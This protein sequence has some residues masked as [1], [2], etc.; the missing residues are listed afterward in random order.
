MT[1]GA[2]AADLPVRKSPP[3]GLQVVAP[4]FTWTG[5]YA[6]VHAGWGIAAPKENAADA[7]VL[8]TAGYSKSV[9]APN[10]FLAGPYIGANYQFSNNVVIG[11]EA[12]YSFSAVK[13]KAHGLGD[14][15]FGPMAY[16]VNAR[17]QN[18]G[19]VLGR[20]G[21][22]F[23]RWRPYVTAGFAWGRAKSTVQ[24]PGFASANANDH[25]GWVAGA[26][27][28]YAATNNVILRAEAMY[29]DL[30][31]KRYGQLVPVRVHARGGLARVG[32]SYKF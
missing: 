28:E 20:L 1:V 17:L 4:A 8:F 25:T 19:T 15:G 26:G 27:V 21:Y 23:D 24:I 30:G 18:L 29:V 16:S 13:G 11:L 14:A 32:V 3:P 7:S 9:N 2:Q 6:G 31:E 12:D 10:G 5:V 22:A